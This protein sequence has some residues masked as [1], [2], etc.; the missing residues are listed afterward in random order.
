MTSSGGY[1][2]FET[3]IIGGAARRPGWQPDTTWRGWRIDR[4]TLK[5]LSIDLPFASSSTNLS[6]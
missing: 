3:A 1:E 6:M 4:Y 5:N 2:R